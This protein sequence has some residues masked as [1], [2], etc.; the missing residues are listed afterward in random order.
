LRRREH[1]G[2]APL[3]AR[4]PGVMAFWTPGEGAIPKQI[5]QRE[6]VHNPTGDYTSSLHHFPAKLATVLR[7]Q[8]CDMIGIGSGTCDRGGQAT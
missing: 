8:D 2:G 7:R 4:L 3:V 6:E 1:H 5:R